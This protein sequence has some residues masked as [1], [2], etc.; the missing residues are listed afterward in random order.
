MNDMTQERKKSMGCGGC[1]L[2]A[3]G[4]IVLTIAL[5]V[6]GGYYTLMHTAYPLKKVAQVIEQ[7]APPASPIL[8]KDISGSFS[9]GARIKTLKWENGEVENLCITYDNLA[10]SIRSRRF[11]FRE[12]S[13]TKAHISVFEPES[14]S[15]TKDPSTPGTSDTPFNW[16]LFQIDKLSLSDIFLTNR[17]TGFS[18]A[19]PKFEWTGFKWEKGTTQFGTIKADTDQFKIETGKATTPGFI[20]R[21]T[22]TL[23]PRLHPS[24]LKEFSFDAEIG[25]LGSN[26]P[27]RVTAFDKAF[28]ATVNPD[29]T[30]TL[31]IQALNVASYF[32]DLWLQDVNLDI[33]TQKTGTEFPLN[34]KS[35]AFN[36]GKT[37]FTVQP[38]MLE[39]SVERTKTFRLLEANAEVEGKKIHYTLSIKDGSEKVAHQLTSQPDMSP[40][41]LVALI[42]FGKP[43]ADLTAAE[44]TTATKLQ[45]LLTP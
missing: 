18:I 42:L 19:I 15:K 37:R 12:I 24:I 25:P 35:G 11:I 36:L 9:T 17:L 39:N 30:G 28:T 13:V 44:K 40:D 38:A 45:A 6:G 14:S 22:G 2:Y 7:A 32:K 10:Q 5:V 27:C 43:A 4:G 26:T 20:T 1:F 23:R 8:I 3:L 21:L 34:I 29:G 31:K 41:E 16:D 33:E